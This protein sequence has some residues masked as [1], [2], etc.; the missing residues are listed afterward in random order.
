MDW[1]RGEDRNGSGICDVILSQEGSTGCVLL[2]SRSVCKQLALLLL[3]LALSKPSSTRL[4][5]LTEPP[6]PPTP[7]PFYTLLLY[8]YNR[9]AL[10]PPCNMTP[11]IPQPSTIPTHPTQTLADPGISNP[12]SIWGRGDEGWGGEG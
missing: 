2:S 6:L 4:R 9:L 11:P 10:R 12:S 3:R 1:R 7:Y 8:P 5:T